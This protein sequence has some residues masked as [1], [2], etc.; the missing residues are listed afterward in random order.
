MWEGK[1]LNFNVIASQ[2]L[3]LLSNFCYLIYE[4]TQSK[5]IFYY[6]IQVTLL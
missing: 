1:R 6:P 4:T 2:I 5:I 3:N